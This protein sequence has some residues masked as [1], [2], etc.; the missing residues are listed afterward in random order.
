[1]DLH[2]AELLLAGTLL[3]EVD[4]LVLGLELPAKLG[5]LLRDHPLLAG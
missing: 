4:G 2:L 1:M 5:P 3:G